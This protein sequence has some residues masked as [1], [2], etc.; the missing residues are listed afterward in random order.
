MFYSPL[1]LS[2]SKS[3][4]TKMSPHHH[5]QQHSHPDLQIIL[6][7]SGSGGLMER[8]STTGADI[9]SVDHRVDLAD[10]VAR[11]RPGF[12][13]RGAPVAVQGNMDP[14][15]LFGSREAI[16]RRIIETVRAASG[17]GVG[18]RHVMN[19]GHGVLVGTPEDAVAHFFEVGRSVHERL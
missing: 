14:G 13:E 4:K 15:V 2:L 16:E 17:A 7:I 12:E 19:L 10:A 3:L 8:M 18:S 9:I 6:Y 11:I 1:S 5:Q